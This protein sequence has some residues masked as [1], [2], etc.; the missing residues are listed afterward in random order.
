MSFFVGGRYRLSLYF[1][2]KMSFKEISVSSCAHRICGIE[3]DFLLHGIGVLTQKEQAFMSS[4]NDPIGTD[5]T[6]VTRVSLVLY[7]ATFRNS[8]WSM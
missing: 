4:S 6:G 3:A 8:A 7:L 5:I 2:Q 1:K